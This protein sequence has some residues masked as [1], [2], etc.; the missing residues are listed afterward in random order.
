MLAP[1]TKPVLLRHLYGLATAYPAQ[2]LSYNKML[3]QLHDAGNTTTL[4]HYLQLL[5]AAFLVSGLG[6]IPAPNSASEAAARNL[7]SGTTPS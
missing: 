5:G 6:N 3:G 1:V 2:I 7:F 4:A